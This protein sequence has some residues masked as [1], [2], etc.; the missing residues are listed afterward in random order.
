MLTWRH[1][2]RHPLFV[3][4]WVWLEWEVP[5]FLARHAPLPVKRAMLYHLV[6]EGRT[7]QGHDGDRATCMRRGSATRCPL[8][9][10]NSRS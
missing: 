4:R 10:R 1:W 3:A 5:A 7:G 8:S 6:A 9:A 2:L